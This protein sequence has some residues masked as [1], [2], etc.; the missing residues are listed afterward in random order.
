MQNIAAVILA[1]G[2]SSRFGKPKQLIQFRDKSLVRRTVDLAIE[3]GCHPVAAVIGS[4][5]KKMKAEL[6]NAPVAIV[7]N[8]NW[9][10]GIG[11][12]IRAG[13]QRLLESM[14]RPKAIVLLT[15]DQPFVK[16][17]TIKQL[18]TLRDETN[19]AIIASR[20]EN[21]LG[22]PALFDHSCFSELLGLDDESGA[23][24]IIMLKRDRVAEFPFPEG[25]I[26]IDTVEDFE[27]IKDGV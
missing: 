27:K 9:E 15:C 21:T 17:A 20:Y 16:A 13:V 26:D 25:K 11:T 12:S 3:A 2:G 19:K 4:D 1:A 22:I 24:P 8:Q 5:R 23:K 7:E 14:P 6:K 18:I 10:R